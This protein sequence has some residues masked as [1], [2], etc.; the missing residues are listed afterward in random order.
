VE[1]IAE[2]K[3]MKDEKLPAFLATKTEADA[4]KSPEQMTRQS[5]YQTRSRTSQSSSEKE[6]EPAAKRSKQQ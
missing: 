4:T 6:D 2:M 5:R 3:R 1:A